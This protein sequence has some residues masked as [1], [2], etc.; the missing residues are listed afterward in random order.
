MVL[1]DV[2]LSNA[3]AEMNRY[4]NVPVVASDRDAIGSLRISSVMRAGDS[5]A[6]AHAV[7]R[8]HSI[9]VRRTGGRIGLDNQAGDTRWQRVEAIRSCL[10]G[11]MLCDF[12]CSCCRFLSEKSLC[13][14][15]RI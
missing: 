14:Y 6:F 8:L 9:N 5:E 11:R 4:S 1:D 13:F 7:A 3:V 15:L 10:K 2:P 12:G